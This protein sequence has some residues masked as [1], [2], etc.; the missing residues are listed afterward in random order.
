MKILCLSDLH[1]RSNAVSD[2]L[3]TQK[4]SPFLREITAT[5]A[6]VSPDVVIVTGDTVWSRQVRKLS[7]VLRKLISGDI[8]IVATLG[9]HEFWERTFEETLTELKEQTFNDK[10]IFYLDLIGAVEIGGL[11]FVGG[12]LFFDGS[13][14][15]RE[16]QRIDEWDGWQDWRI[17]E[18]VTRYLEF[19]AYYVDMI[20]SKMKPGI[21]TVLCTHHLPH[22]LLNGHEPSHYSFYSG[23]KDLVHELPFDARFDNYLICGHTHRRVIGEVIPGFMGV[24]VGSDYDH[25]QS[26]VLE[27]G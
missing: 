27:I 15:I 17:G 12:T 19:N 6:E 11:N 8:P 2:F 7:F 10:N 16:S 9:N 3:N 20:H 1:L 18:I 5:V 21:S 25:L 14:R 22:V 26:F 13:M 24:N 4:A 23:M